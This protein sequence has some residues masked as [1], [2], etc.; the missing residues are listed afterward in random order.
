VSKLCIHLLKLKML[1]YV[2]VSM[3][4]KDCWKFSEGLSFIFVRF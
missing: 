3:K 4:V 2:G 1:V